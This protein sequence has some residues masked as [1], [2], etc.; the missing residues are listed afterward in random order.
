MEYNTKKHTNKG[1]KDGSKAQGLSLATSIN[2][3]LSLQ[4]FICQAL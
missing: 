2:F 3:V 1:S 4:L